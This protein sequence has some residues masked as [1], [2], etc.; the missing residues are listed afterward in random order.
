[1]GSSLRVSMSLVASSSLT[2]F[3]CLICSNCML[4]FSMVTGSSVTGLAASAAF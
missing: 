2:D 4:L 3:S 1:M